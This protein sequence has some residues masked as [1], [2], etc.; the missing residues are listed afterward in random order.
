MQWSISGIA[1]KSLAAIVTLGVLAGCVSQ[2][3]R[4]PPQRTVFTILHESNRQGV[5]EPCGCEGNPFGGIDREK[6]AV[7]LFRKEGNALFYVDSGNAFFAKSAKASQVRSLHKAKDLVG[8]LNLI[9]LDVVSPGPFDYAA[10]I[11]S[12]QKLSKEAQFPFVSTNVLDNSGKTAFAPYALIEKKGLI[13]AFVSA[14]P[15]VSEK[16]GYVAKPVDSVLPQTI[17]ELRK[18]SDVV[19]LLSQMGIDQDEKLAKALDVDI[20]VG[21]DLSHS[22]NTA[23]SLQHGKTLLVDTS[24]YGYRLGKLDVDL[25]LPFQGFS[26]PKAI[27]QNLAIIQGAEKIARANPK[28][29]SKQEYVADLKAKFQIVAIPGGSDYQHGLIALDKKRFGT[30]NE[31]SKLIQQSKKQTRLRSL[32]E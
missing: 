23:F 5:V 17:Q 24:S 2:P 20:I 3:T 26:S 11:D 14:T 30:P 15:S 10:G 7:D 32:S 9:G 25:R 22:S 21:A 6:N 27:E 16:T 4:I 8:I 31:I 18:K 19:V 28:D 13:I 12:L 1:R 29:K